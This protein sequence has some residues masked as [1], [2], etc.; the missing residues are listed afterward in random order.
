MQSSA[1]FPG[2]QYS[3]HM[4]E[5]RELPYVRVPYQESGNETTWPTEIVKPDILTVTTNTV[6]FPEPSLP[7]M[8]AWEWGYN[9]HIPTGL[10]SSSL[11]NCVA[12]HLR[13]KMTHTHQCWQDKGHKYYLDCNIC[14]MC[15]VYS[16]LYSGKI[17]REKTFANF[18]VLWLFAKVFSVKF[19]GVASFG[20]A[21]V[22]NPWKSYLARTLHTCSLHTWR[23]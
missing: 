10:Y 19:G 15:T 14:F 12:V 8:R 7:C 21:K 22:S 9:K 18:S 6:S 20:T 17:S 2:P 13:Q 5:K 11:I 16:I 23:S 3:T 4:W 1:M